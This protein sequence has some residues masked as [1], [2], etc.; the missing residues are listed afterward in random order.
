MRRPRIIINAAMSVDGKIALV[1]GKRIKI[2]DEDDFRRVH[3]MRARVDAILVG[4]NTIL[5]D[6]PKLTVKG[7]YINNAKN[8]VRIILDSKLRIP[9]SAKVLNVPGK[10][11]IATTKNAPN[12]NLNA[13]II[14][15]GEDIVDLECLMERLWDRGIKS[16]MVEG[17]GTVISSFLKKNLFDEL[18]IFIGSLGIGGDAPTLMEGIG[19]KDE[20]EIIRLKLL[21]CRT[22]GY[23]VLLRYGVY[24][25]NF[26]E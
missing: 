17:G 2:S 6:N 11:I 22:L 20:K 12:R 5:K 3:E 16:V 23:G 9:K 1:G 21:E 24:D 13:E 25:E 7:K 18:D 8:P 14:R 19:A 15:C 26:V 4:I 10:T